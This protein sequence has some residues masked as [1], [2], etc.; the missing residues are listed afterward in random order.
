M[1]DQISRRGLLKAAA[2]AAVAG[3][4]G[5]ISSGNS[6]NTPKS[7]ENA[8]EAEDMGEWM[9]KYSD[10]TYAEFAENSAQMHAEEYNR[11]MQMSGTH[12]D[13]APERDSVDN[14]I[15]D[16]E[17]IE[18]TFTEVESDTPAERYQAEL[19]LQTNS[20]SVFSDFENFEEHED[21]YNERIAQLF[22]TVMMPTVGTLFTDSHGPDYRASQADPD[23]KAVE[24]INY[25]LEDNAGNEEAL[26]YDSSGADELSET[27]DEV[28]NQ[29]EAFYEKA[30]KELE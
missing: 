27:Y 19:R 23:S 20:E 9:Q 30:L 17:S 12:I 10:L 1:E 2:G 8:I 13:S 16:E 14:P 25:V 6:E 4:A 22:G 3:S 7:T 28:M 26:Q 5:C 15:V 11:D 21:L 24:G 29:K 18:L